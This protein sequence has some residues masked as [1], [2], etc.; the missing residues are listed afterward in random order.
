MNSLYIGRLYITFESLGCAA[1]SIEAALDYVRNRNQFGKKVIQFQIIQEK[2]LRTIAEIESTMML[3][4][5][6]ASL[7]LSG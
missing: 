6:V 1:G 2:L 7:Y 5:R 4:L 3:A